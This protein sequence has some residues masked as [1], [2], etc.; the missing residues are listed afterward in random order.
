MTVVAYICYYAIQYKTAKDFIFML[1]QILC[2]DNGWDDGLGIFQNILFRRGTLNMCGGGG[3][4][5]II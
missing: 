3:L 4:G 2:L 1:T 5:G